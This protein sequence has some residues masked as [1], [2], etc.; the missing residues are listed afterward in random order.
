[1]HMDGDTYFAGSV[2]AI[3]CDGH[4]NISLQDFILRYDSWH[5]IGKINHL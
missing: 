3:G 1:M 4:N 5:Q 2:I